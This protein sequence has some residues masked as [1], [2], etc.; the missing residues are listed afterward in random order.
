MSTWWCACAPNVTESLPVGI[1]LDLSPASFGLLVDL[2]AGVGTPDQ[3]LADPA[4]MAAQ[5]HFA[6]LPV[7]GLDGADDTRLDHRN[8]AG[9]LGGA[10]HEIDAHILAALPR[11]DDRRALARQQSLLTQPSE[12]SA[13]RTRRQVSYSCTISIGSPALVYIQSTE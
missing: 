9:I 7:T 13:S 3:R 1:E 5:A 10:L 12:P 2:F 11:R 6:P 4:G 8:H